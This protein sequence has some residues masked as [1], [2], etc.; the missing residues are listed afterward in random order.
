MLVLYRTGNRPIPSSSPS[1]PSA[2]TMFAESPL[3]LGL[4]VQLQ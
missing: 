3:D 4:S 2:Q 1:V